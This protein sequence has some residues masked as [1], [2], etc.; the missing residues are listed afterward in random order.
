EI[1][2]GKESTS[3]VEI[4]QVNAFEI[5][6][7]SIQPA[8]SFAC[9]AELFDIH[10]CKRP[11]LPAAGRV[12]VSSH[13]SS[14]ARASCAYPLYCSTK[15]SR[16]WYTMICQQGC[17]LPAHL[18]HVMQCVGSSSVSLPQKSYAHPVSE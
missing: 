16:T 4:R 11:I 12:T 14:F 15:G 1:R 13:V 8:C 3:Q 7:T 18:L 6:A 9:A 17:V 10:S 5:E 2:I